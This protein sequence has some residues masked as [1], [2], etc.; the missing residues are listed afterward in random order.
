MAGR[1][2]GGIKGQC[3]R[4]SPL[5]YRR[6]NSDKNAS[7]SLQA[8]DQSE[9]LLTLCVWMMLL[10]SRA[11]RLA[12]FLASLSRLCS[13]AVPLSFCSSITYERDDR[14]SLD[15]E[16]TDLHRNNQSSLRVLI[17]AALINGP[18]QKA[19]VVY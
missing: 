19:R 8:A 18:V 14:G 17:N 15:L 1:L 5:H 7:T 3:D 10:Y 11:T 12:H 16:A 13:S 2:P 4:Y 6:S 9:L